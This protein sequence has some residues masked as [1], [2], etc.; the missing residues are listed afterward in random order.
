M[1]MQAFWNCSEDVSDFP[2]PLATFCLVLGLPRADDNQDQSEITVQ[3]AAG[4][5]HP[6]LGIKNGGKSAAYYPYFEK[7]KKYIS[8]LSK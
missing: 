6:P 7:G 3:N 1:Q 4:H 8:S 5:P 2:A